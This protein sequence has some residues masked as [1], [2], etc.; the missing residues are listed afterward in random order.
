MN[1]MNVLFT[2]YKYG[3]ALGSF[4][5]NRIVLPKTGDL[6]RI[7]KKYYEVNNIIYNYDEME[8]EVV[9]EEDY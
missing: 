9:L 5:F 8:I 7:E 3:E 6:V 2:D 1:V 4:D